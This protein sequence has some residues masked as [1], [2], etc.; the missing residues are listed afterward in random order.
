MTHTLVALAA[1]LGLAAGAW[2]QKPVKP[3][4]PKSQSEMVAL[5]AVQNA[6][7]ADSRL[8]AIQELLSKFADTEFREFALQM[9]TISHQQKDDFDKMLIAGERTLEVN[10]DNVVVLITL[11]QSIPQR[12][13]EHDLDKDEK[14]GK[15]EKFAKRAQVQLPVLEKFN[16]Q[17]TDEEWAG[18]RKAAMSQTHESLGMIAFVRKDYAAAEKSF[19]AAVEVSPQV[20]PTLLYRLAMVY[21]TQNRHD[22][23]IAALDK[24]IAA[25]G[26]KVGDK[27]LAAE[28][29][30]ASMKAKAGAKPPAPATPPQVDIKRP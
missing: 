19:Q 7:D 26:V 1:A 11:A 23:A 30:A 24:A 8:K 12:T 17:I 21:A 14:L 2:A 20:D 16:P 18:Y 29:K 10:P 22:E 15:A 13:R 4:A 9:E 27:D 28:Q 5:M 3:P 6:P 25:G